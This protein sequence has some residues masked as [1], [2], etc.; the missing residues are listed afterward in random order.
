MD[1]E[2]AATAHSCLLD[3]C[4]LTSGLCLHLDVEFG[5]TGEQGGDILICPSQLMLIL[6]VLGFEVA[7]LSI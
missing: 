1:V 7:Q 4:A 5:E 3:V 2:F 6:P